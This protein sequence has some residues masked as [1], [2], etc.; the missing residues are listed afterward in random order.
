[1]NKDEKIGQIES[2]YLNIV[3][4]IRKAE[5]NMDST[6]YIKGEATAYRRNLVSDIVAVP[7]TGSIDT[8]MAFWVR[9]KGY[10]VIFDPGVIFEEYAPADDSGYIKQKTIRAANWMRN[11]MIFKD[12]ILNPKY[13][14][15]GLF[16][17]PFNTLVL[18]I[19]PLLPLIAFLTF[20]IGIVFDSA[21]FLSILYPLIGILILLFIISK[22][23]IPLLVE[24]E[25]SLL[26]GIYQIF[27]SR[28]GHDK[29]ERVESTRRIV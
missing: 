16:T 19:F 29:I 27:V 5:S 4:F 3:N 17:L 24:L 12:M 22:N 23:L 13:G 2:L 15:F 18:F 6:F 10:K 14:K 25:I 20:V 1:M 21:F 8:S 7:N 28:V 26:K 11:L 9:K